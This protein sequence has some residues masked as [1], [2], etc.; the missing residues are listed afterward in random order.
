MSKTVLFQTIQFK[1]STQ[2]N[3]IRPIDSTLS[4]TTTPGQNDGNGCVLHIPQNSSITRTSPSDCLVSYA[5]HMPMESYPS[6]EM[7]FFY[8]AAL[9]DCAI[10][11]LRDHYKIDCISRYLFP[12]SLAA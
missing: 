9:A 7:Q 12:E 11:F 1:I 10:K 5:K 4:G 3:S 6:A 2:F 8:S